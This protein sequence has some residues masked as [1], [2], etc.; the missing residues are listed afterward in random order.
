V[1]GNRKDHTGSGIQRP[2]TRN[3]HHLYGR[4]TLHLEDDLRRPGA[5][6]KYA[7]IA[8]KHI[9]T[10][11]VKEPNVKIEIRWCPS[12]QGIEGNEVAGEW[13]KLVAD[14][15]DAHGVEWFSFTNP[16]G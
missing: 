1:S 15:P 12:H 14:V 5:G 6:P 3:S 9:A 7:I 11:R 2:Y 16:R 4:A 13:A 10:L 8:R